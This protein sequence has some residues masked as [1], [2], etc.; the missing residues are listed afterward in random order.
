M[1]RLINLIYD[2]CAIQAAEMLKTSFI[3]ANVKKYSELGNF[4]PQHSD[5][6][7]LLIQSFPILVKL[8]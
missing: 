1:K 7:C 6:I 5:I 4:N 3:K 8:F 2:H